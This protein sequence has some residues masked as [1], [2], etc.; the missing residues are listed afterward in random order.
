MVQ[1]VP[2]LARTVA[3]MTGQPIYKT[4]QTIW[5][6]FDA[7]AQLLAAADTFTVSNFGTFSAPQR[8]PRAARNPRTGARIDIPARNEPHFKPTGR[9]VTMVHTGDTASSIRKPRYTFTY[10]PNKHRR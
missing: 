10:T 5:A 4:E 9:L 8:P 2:D 3:K 6:T 1:H 7:L